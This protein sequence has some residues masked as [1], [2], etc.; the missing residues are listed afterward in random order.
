[1]YVPYLLLN[2][3]EILD[4]LAA[5]L[6]LWLPLQEPLV[7]GVQVPLPQEVVQTLRT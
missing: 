5:F 1:M 2:L 3:E 4:M 6:L 7:S